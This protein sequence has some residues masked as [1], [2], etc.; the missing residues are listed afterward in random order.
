[1]AVNTPTEYIVVALCRIP[2]TGSLTPDVSAQFIING[3]VE[4]GR[5]PFCVMKLCM[6]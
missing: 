2:W 1:M 3:E 4:D 5:G 6:S